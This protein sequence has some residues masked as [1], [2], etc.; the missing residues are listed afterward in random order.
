MQ[1]PG[2]TPQDRREISQ[3]ALKE[4][5]RAINY[6]S[7]DQFRTQNYFALSALEDLFGYS[8]GALPLAITFH[9]FSVK[10]PLVTNPLVL[11]C[12]NC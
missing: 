7:F 1:K 12:S 8:P 10:K 5:H 11:S 2:A 6:H 9:A 4:R 3:R